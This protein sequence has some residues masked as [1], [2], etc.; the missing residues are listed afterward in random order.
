MKLEDIKPPM[1]VYDVHS[2]AM[3][4]TYVRSLGCW[5]VRILEVDQRLRIVVASWNGNPKQNFYERQWKKWRVKKPVL[6]SES[7]GRQRLQTREEKK[8]AKELK[9]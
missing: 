1:T 2:Y 6:V 5:P 9:A 8:V 3:G 7:F 4:N